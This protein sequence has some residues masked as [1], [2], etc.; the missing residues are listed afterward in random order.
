MDGADEILKKVDNVQITI[1][2][3][4]ENHNYNRP[5]KNG[6]GTFDDIYNSLLKYA[7]LYSDKFILRVNVTIEDYEKVINFMSKLKNDGLNNCLLYTSRC[8]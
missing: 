4:K 8:V 5:Y 1:D 2:A 7:F 6:N 3:T